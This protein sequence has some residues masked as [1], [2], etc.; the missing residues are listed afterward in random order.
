MI[1]FFKEDSGSMHRANAGQTFKRQAALQL[2][3]SHQIQEKTGTQTRASS[4]KVAK[5]QEGIFLPIQ[6]N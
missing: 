5:R 1:Y 6:M 4:Q 2:D 3:F